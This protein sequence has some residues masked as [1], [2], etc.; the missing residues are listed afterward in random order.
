MDRLSLVVVIQ[1]EGYFEQ[2]QALP[3]I[4]ANVKQIPCQV[5]E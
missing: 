2:K 3:L 4:A 1:T 5:L